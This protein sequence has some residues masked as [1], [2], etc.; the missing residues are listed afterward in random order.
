MR[1]DLTFYLEKFEVRYLLKV[2]NLVARYWKNLQKLYTVCNDGEVLL[3]PVFNKFKTHHRYIYSLL[4][5]DAARDKLGEELEWNME[6]LTKRKQ[7]L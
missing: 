1:L 5:S 3:L 7:T 4:E 2:I 6:K